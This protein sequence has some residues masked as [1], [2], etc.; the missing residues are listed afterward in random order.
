MVVGYLVLALEPPFEVVVSVRVAAGAA[1]AAF[2]VAAY[3]MA[4]ELAPDARQGEAA[5][6]ATVGSYAGL[7]VGPAVGVLV[8]GDDRFTLLWVGPLPWSESRPCAGPSSR[9]RGPTRGG[10]CGLAAAAQRGHAGCCPPSRGPRV[11]RFQRFRRALRAR[12][13]R[14]AAR[15]RLRALRGR[16]HR[17]AGLRPAA[18]GPA[19]LAAHR[20]DRVR[21]DRDRPRRHRRLGVPGW[22]L[23]WDGGIR[24]RPGACVP[25]PRPAC[26]GKD[27]AQRAERRGRYGRGLR[28]RG[29]RHRRSSARRR[30][31]CVD[32]RAVFLVSALSAVL[33]FTLLQLVGRKAPKA[34]IPAALP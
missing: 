28:G 12:P 7:A 16:G 5:S 10:P 19:G 9:R 29:A 30:R 25:E 17:R 20:V 33:G 26:D 24:L 4:I 14:R 15:L 13:R 32:D 18:A 6:L 2:V 21:R 27:A 31:R 3:S 8:L 11:R 22:A 23:L 34:D 1:E